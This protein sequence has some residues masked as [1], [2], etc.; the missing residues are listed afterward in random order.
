[1]YEGTWTLRPCPRRDVVA[2]AKALGVS[3]TTAGVLV[4]RGYDDPAAAEAFLS[5]ARPEH[6]PFLLGDM[7]GACAAIRA[8]IDGGRRICVHGDYDVDGICA[9][10]LA[11][12]VLR[13]LGAE[14][15][16]HLPSR[17]EEGYGVSRETLA[18]FAR[19]G[20]G[21][22][23][24]V[25]CGITAVE[26]VAEAKAAGL[27]VV[28]TDH[29]RPGDALPDCPVVATRPSDYPFP[30]LCGTGAVFKLAQALGATESVE[31]H[32]DL[33][34]LATVAD[35]VPLLDENRGLVVAGLRQL[36]RTSKPGLR[37]LM[38]VAHVDPAAVDAGAI[39]FRLAPRINAAGRLGHPR[40]ALDLLLTDEPAEAERLAGEL[41]TL[42]RERQQVEDRI[43]REALDQVEEWPEAKRRSR[44]YVLAGAQWHRGVIG[45]VASR[46][47]ERFH[48]PVVLI[49]GAEEEW[50][51]SGRSIPTFDLHNA[52]AAC[53]QVLARF[54]GH[55]AAAGLAVVP[56][57]VDEFA[58]LFA[59]HADGVLADDDLTPVV[60]VDA[61]VDGREL[62]LG[63]CEEL[64]RIA[65]FGLG[66]PAVTLLAV[67]CELSELGAVGEGKHLKLAV[68]ADGARSGA[69]AF[70][71]GAQLDRYRRV[72]RYDVAFRL[73]ANS[74]NGTV[75]PQLQVKR[76]FDTP[77]GYAGLRDRLARE[78]RL[79]PSARSAEAL[80]IFAELGLDE[81]PGGR[82][83]LVESQTFC[84]LLHEP[85][86]L[87][88]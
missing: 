38:R 66:N 88:A 76:I 4:R 69:I 83:H 21:L 78:W 35:V 31:K 59:Q 9:T 19:E 29:H 1:M 70:G 86:R 45:I 6:D 57:N 74:W 42:N 56:E 8:A 79:D 39:A 10:A 80:A 71:Q 47:V 51:G 82:R 55:R 65:P 32:L 58:R 52:L 20:C 53:S 43:L 64:E 3:E 24:T 60:R 2:L 17:F 15:E 81:D 12:L 68:S 73:A 26:E 27:E 63:L 33:V 61:V 77:E 11:V 16:W 22:L 14:V 40:A 54:G 30:E 18:R 48:R 46:L 25:D 75:A 50:T 84:A 67:G 41:E 36:A 49:A 23:L 62:T 72:G 34:A 85:V 28:V 5:A 7:R 37:A 13:D 44:G 87:A